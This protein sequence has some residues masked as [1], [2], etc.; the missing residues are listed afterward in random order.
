MAR[1]QPEAPGL[2]SLSVAVTGGAVRHRAN[3]T[4]V[5]THLLNQLRKAC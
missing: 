3:M 5:V 4:R 2:G 1:H